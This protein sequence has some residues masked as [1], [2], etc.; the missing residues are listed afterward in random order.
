MDR[1]FENWK[2]YM[3]SSNSKKNIGDTW[4]VITE[5]T[6]DR[7]MTKYADLGFIVISADRSCSAEKG[8]PC[9][10]EEE[11]D[12][13]STNKENE[14]NI[15]ADIRAAGFGFIPSYGG[16]REKS[17]SGKEDIEI[18]REKSFIIPVG[19]YGGEESPHRLMGWQKHGSDTE[20]YSFVSTKA[21]ALAVD[22]KSHK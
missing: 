12:Q 7:V 9:S 22:R 14:Q 20:K 8:G 18:L 17:A 11:A 4:Q 1:I 2:R 5:A 16:F 19:G 6:L 21:A 10:D 13:T 3:G 15:K